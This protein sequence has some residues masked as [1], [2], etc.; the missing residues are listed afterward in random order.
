VEIP[1]E[2]VQ[3]AQYVQKEG[4]HIPP[5]LVA[6]PQKDRKLVYCHNNY[7][8]TYYYYE[9]RPV[10]NGWMYLLKQP[11]RRSD[12]SLRRRLGQKKLVQVA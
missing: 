1:V 12:S 8:G 7:A 10:D 5:R 4:G 9:L 11:R 6:V 3:K 2:K